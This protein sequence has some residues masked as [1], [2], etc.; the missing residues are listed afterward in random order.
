M[1]FLSDTVATYSANLFFRPGFFLVQ[2]SSGSPW[3]PSPRRFTYPLSSQCL[4]WEWFTDLQIHLQVWAPGTC[5]QALN[6]TQLLLSLKCPFCEYI[7]AF[8]WSKCQSLDRAATVLIDSRVPVW[9]DSHGESK[10]L[11]SWEKWKDNPALRW[12]VH[13]LLHLRYWSWTLQ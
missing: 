13:V 2:P 3:M 6:T 5:S 4:V 9:A 7:F 1:N 12:L 10:S 8:K 11:I